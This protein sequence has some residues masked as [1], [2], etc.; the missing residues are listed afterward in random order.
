MSNKKILL[1]VLLTSVFISGCIFDKDDNGKQINGSKFIPQKDLPAGFTYMAIHET[2][3]DIGN[4][5]INAIEGVYRNSKGE[6]MYIQALENNSPSALINEYKLRYKD[7]NWDPF[8]EIFVNGHK[9]TKVKDYTTMNGQ[10]TPK[11]SIIWATEK[12]MMLVGSSIDAQS[13]MNLAS[14]TGI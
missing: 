4:S 9:A 10:Q 1:L 8:E 11:Y 2:S 5:S 14:A 13:V 12:Y 7:A 6:D 3:V